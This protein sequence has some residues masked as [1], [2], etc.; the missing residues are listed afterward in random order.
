MIVHATTKEASTRSWVLFSKQSQKE[1]Y[2]VQKVQNECFCSSSNIKCF[3][4]HALDFMTPH[5]FAGSRLTSDFTT[6]CDECIDL[7]NRRTPFML[8]N[9]TPVSLQN[10]AFLEKCETIS[11]YK[12][13][14]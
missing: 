12:F 13:A 4:S 10:P 1:A 3:C 7:L 6:K 14:L 11:K 9:K 8:G 2:F 5:K